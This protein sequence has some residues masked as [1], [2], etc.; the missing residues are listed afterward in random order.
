MALGPGVSGNKGIRY[1]C[2]Y[3]SVDVCLYLCV[4]IYIYVRS[5]A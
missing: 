1:V 3:I 5:R 4:Y 2:I